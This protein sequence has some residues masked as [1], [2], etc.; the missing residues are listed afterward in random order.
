[1]RCSVVSDADAV[2][3]PWAAGAAGACALDPDGDALEPDWAEVGD[4]CVSVEDLLGEE[5]CD[6]LRCA[7]L[8]VLDSEP[9]LLDGL[10]DEPFCDCE[11]EGACDDEG[12]C[13]D[14][15]GPVLG[16]CPLLLSGAFDGALWSA[17]PLSELAPL[18]IEPDWVDWLAA[19][20]SLDPWATA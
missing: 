17:L 1:V 11:D 15:D 20:A 9:L 3:L 6:W 19:G 8:W 14:V 18:S 16:A 2:P 7:G 4:R 10:A 13:P 5:D 12:A